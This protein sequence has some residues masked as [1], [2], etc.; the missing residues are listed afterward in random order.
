[1]DYYHGVGGGGGGGGVGSDTTFLR[2]L[3]KYNSEN[4][5]VAKLKYLNTIQRIV[6]LAIWSV[7]FTSQWNDKK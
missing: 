1:M 3:K 4:V 7:Q 2:M 6:L 5:S